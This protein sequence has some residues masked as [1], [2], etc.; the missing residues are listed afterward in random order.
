LS[1]IEGF[2]K[3]HELTLLDVYAT[4]DDVSLPSFDWLS[5]TPSTDPASCDDI[6][7]YVILGNTI[8]STPRASNPVALR[9][10]SGSSTLLL[11]SPGGSPSSDPFVTGV[12]GGIP[13]RPRASPTMKK[14]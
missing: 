9:P 14:T 3:D 13:S 10:V 5:L 11:P 1:K 6:T 4:P 12:Y 7:A 2:C 8:L